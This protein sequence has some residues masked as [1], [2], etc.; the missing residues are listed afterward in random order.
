MNEI[1]EKQREKYRHRGWRCPLCG[2]I[3]PSDTHV[4]F[5]IKCQAFIIKE[6]RLLVENNEE[7]PSI[8]KPDILKCENC[9]ARM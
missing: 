9:D 8:N 2:Y 5:N 4:C 7:N 1:K 3:N 6:K